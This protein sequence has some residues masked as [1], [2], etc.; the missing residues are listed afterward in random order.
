MNKNELANRVCEMLYQN[1]G[2]HC[3]AIGKC[4]ECKKESTS[5][6]G[7]YCQKCINKVLKEWKEAK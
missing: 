3:S 4:M 2:M 7:M 5:A 1:T 6:L